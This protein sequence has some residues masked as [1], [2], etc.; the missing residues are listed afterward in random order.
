MSSGPASTLHD[1]AARELRFIR[2]TMA[3][4]GGFTAVPGRGGM[5][6]GVTALVTA[7]A[8]T[9]L[10]SDRWWLAAWLTDAAVAA[11]IGLAAMRLKARTAGVSL[12][13]AAARRF[14]LAF[15]PAIVAAVVLTSLLAARGMLAALPGTWLLLYGV[16]VISGGSTSV[17]PVPLFGAALMTLGCVALAA[18]APWGTP[19]MAAGFGLGHIVTGFVIA[20]GYGG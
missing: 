12:T 13:G 10:E 19:L 7:A 9:R 4:A 18:P 8:T 3:R 17:P 11:A 2:E 6:M 14:A 16:A 15:V 1:H 5:A 20:R